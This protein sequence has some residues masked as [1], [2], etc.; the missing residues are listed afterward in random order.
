MT[1]TTEYISPIFIIITALKS[2]IIYFLDS[3]WEA[4][5]FSPRKMRKSAKIEHDINIKPDI[6]NNKYV[7]T[8]THS[9]AL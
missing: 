4:I 3:E 7:Q 2:L 9:K 6:N 1:R 8:H 5:D